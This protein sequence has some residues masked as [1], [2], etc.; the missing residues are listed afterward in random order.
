MSYASA[1][2]SNF[3]EIVHFLSLFFSN[4]FHNTVKREMLNMFYASAFPV[5]FPEFVQLVVLAFYDLSHNIVKRK[6]IN[7][8]VYKLYV[9]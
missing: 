1:F 6:R 3:P 2:P 9:V 4:P 8:V 5:G 7:L